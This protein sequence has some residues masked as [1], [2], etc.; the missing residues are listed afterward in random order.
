MCLPSASN[1]LYKPAIKTRNHKIAFNKESWSI[2]YSAN[3]SGENPAIKT[4]A[5]MQKKIS[6]YNFIKKFQKFLH[7][8]VLIND[9]K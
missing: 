8:V 3:T 2:D 4:N 1:K 7:K 9:S 6:V 5:K